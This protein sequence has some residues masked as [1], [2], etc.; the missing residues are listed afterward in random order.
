MTVS[1]LMPPFYHDISP[2]N[3]EVLQLVV[4]KWRQI[5]ENAI[6]EFIEPDSN[7]EHAIS[8]GFQ[9]LEKN[10]NLLNFLV[11]YKVR[12]LKQLFLLL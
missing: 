5:C 2:Y 8:T 3:Y 7:L 10:E 9:E 4:S 1:V 11:T 6:P 12:S